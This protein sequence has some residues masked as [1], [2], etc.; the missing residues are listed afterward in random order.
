MVIFFLSIRI[1]IS[2]WLKCRILKSRTTNSTIPLWEFLSASTK[3][4]WQV[5]MLVLSCPRSY[6]I[7]TCPKFHS[8]ICPNKVLIDMLLTEWDAIVDPII[9]VCYQNT[10]S[11]I[12]PNKVLIDMLLTE[13]HAIVDPINGRHI[14]R[15]EHTPF[16]HFLS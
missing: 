16:S 12:C 5:T 11:R 14:S 7:R 15:R 10:F 4:C 2:Y 1:Y 8:R 13:W 6:V 3:Q 9:G